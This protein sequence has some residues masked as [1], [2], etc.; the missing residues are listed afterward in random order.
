MLKTQQYIQQHGLEKLITTYSLVAN[1]SRR[2]PNLVQLCYHQ[3]DTPKNEIT[4]ECRGLILDINNEYSVVSYPFYRFSDYSEKSNAVLD[5][6]SLKFYEK[7]DGSIISLYYY[8]GEWNISTKTIP[9][10]DGKIYNP[11]PNGNKEEKTFRDYFFETFNKLGYKY[12]TDTYMTYVFEFMFGGQG[13]T[14]KNT[15]QISLIM[16]RDIKPVFQATY[17]EVNH[18]ENIRNRLFG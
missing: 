12:P 11:K 1:Y 13:I 9:D 15:E 6:E 14:H 16:V 10:A 3:L 7:L 8:N 17:P 5:M 18:I 4:N 2:Y